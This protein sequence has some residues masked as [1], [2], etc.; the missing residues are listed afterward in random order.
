MFGKR[1]MNSYLSE[2]SLTRRKIFTNCA[3]RFAKQYFFIEKRTD[4]K[5]RNFPF[6]SS[7]DLMI[8]CTR[9][10]LFELLTDLHKGVYWSDKVIISKMRFHVNVNISS[11]IQQ[12]ISLKIKNQLILNG[13][14]RLKKLMKQETLRKILDKSIKEWSF[15][16]RVQSTKFGHLDVYCSPDIVY[17]EGSVWHLVRINFQSE[18]KQP[19]LDLELCSMLLWSK[20]NQY[21]PNLNEKFVIH[22][23]SWHKGKWFYKKI[24]PNQK[25]LQETKQLLEKDVHNFNILRQEFYRSKDYDSLP[26]AKTKLY[27]KRCPYK[28]NCPVNREIK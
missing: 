4:F 15:H 5:K 21:L 9:C 8:K 26:L 27:C 12:K 16:D 19:F 10:V 6:V 18:H 14:R 1:L 7:S 28:I 23:L 24:R 3:R 25:L 2:W 22:G 20:G 11:K 13:F 17:R